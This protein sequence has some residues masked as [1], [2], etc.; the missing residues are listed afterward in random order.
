MSGTVT[1]YNAGTGAISVLLDNKLGS[2]TF[3]SWEVNLSGASGGDG[4][5]GT[6][7]SS[8][9]SGTSGANGANG[10]SGSSG[11]SGVNGANGTSGT[12]GSSGSSGTSG[13]DT[14]NVALNTQ[15]GATY[16]LTTSDVNRLVNMNSASAQTVTIPPNST[17]SIATGSQIL[18]ARQGAGEVTIAPAGGVT[19]YAAQSYYRLNYQYSGATVVKI[20]TDI[21]Y[22]FGD[23]KA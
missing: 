4:S 23:L 17:A 14:A 16:T 8:G 21:W 20:S 11:T 15:T 2:G 5:S 7:G 19:I 6:S 13:I 1:A 18:I 22:V 9:S 10:T 3:S 12:S